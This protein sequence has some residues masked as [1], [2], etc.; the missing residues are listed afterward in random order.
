MACRATS[1]FF[2]LLLSLPLAL[3]GVSS[4]P[5]SSSPTSPSSPTSS[6]PHETPRP[7]FTSHLDALPE[8]GTPPGVASLPK[9]TSVSLVLLGSTRGE[10]GLLETTLTTITKPTD[11]PL[12]SSN[13]PKSTSEALPL[14][15]ATQVVSVF[16]NRTVTGSNLPLVT[17]SIA[18]DTSTSPLILPLLSS[19]LNTTSR[20][21]ER[22]SILLPVLLSKASTVSTTTSTSSPLV[23]TLSSLS[24]STLDSASSV[25]YRQETKTSE[26]HS[27]FA[28]RDS[29]R[30]PQRTLSTNNSL[31]LVQP[32]NSHTDYVNQAPS[33]TQ[34]DTQMSADSLPYSLRPSISKDLDPS[35]ELVSSPSTPPPPPAASPPSPPEH[36]PVFYTPPP[37][38]PLPPTPSPLTTLLA[39]FAKAKAPPS[40][41]LPSP[42]SPTTY[43]G[44]LPLPALT[45]T[46]AP[47]PLDMPPHVLSLFYFLLSP[48]PSAPP[49]PSNTSTPSPTSAVHRFLSPATAVPQG[50]VPPQSSSRGRY[51]LSLT[52]QAGLQYG[53]FLAAVP[54]LTQFTVCLRFQIATLAR[55][56]FLLSYAVHGQDNA[57][58]VFVSP[59]TKPGVGFYVNNVRIKANA[60]IRTRTWY[61]MCATWH[62]DQGQYAIHMDGMLVKKGSKKCPGCE[63]EGGGIA[64][65]GAEQDRPGGG[66][67]PRQVTH[68]HVSSLHLWDQ[69]LPDSALHPY[70]CCSS[71]EAEVEVPLKDAVCEVTPATL[72]SLGKRVIE[73]GVTPVAIM[74]GALFVPLDL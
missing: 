56:H 36:P 32:V 38:P 62:S 49:S 8:P 3:S 54:A 43:Q 41:T 30:I 59:G 72:T 61:S 33:E 58:L 12:V 42:S 46:P 47:N 28:T 26:T 37:L 9:S 21:S 66:F 68:G 31:N 55:S 35:R 39:P 65:L 15:N 2:L 17:A 45:T 67:N 6:G 27:S 5:S 40:P 34:R 48:T 60:H 71:A 69:A 24:P 20:S 10:P 73:W 44:P 29:P 25:S 64:V 22:E 51:S 1:H 11:L 14:I 19:P 57:I 50:C 74:G 7:L 16:A 63:V 13:F 18:N 23:H 70:L 52:P 53:V 4:S